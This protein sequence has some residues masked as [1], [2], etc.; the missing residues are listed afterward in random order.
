MHMEICWVKNKKIPFTSP[1]LWFDMV[2]FSKRVR[3]TPIESNSSSHTIVHSNRIGEDEIQTQNIGEFII[4]NWISCF[5]V[6][7]CDYSIIQPCDRFIQWRLWI[8]LYKWWCFCT[9]KYKLILLYMWQRRFCI[10]FFSALI[11]QVW[12]GFKL[13]ETVRVTHNTQLFRYII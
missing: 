8:D 5:N 2:A 1:L 13:Q 3:A 12:V 11:P 4:I 7:D 6:I 9:Y 10:V